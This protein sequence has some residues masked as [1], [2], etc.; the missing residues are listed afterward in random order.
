MS[1]EAGTVVLTTSAKDLIPS[2]MGALNLKFLTSVYHVRKL[3]T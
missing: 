2:S 1:P 3:V